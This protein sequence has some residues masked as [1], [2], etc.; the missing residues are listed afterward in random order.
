MTLVKGRLRRVGRSFAGYT[1][2]ALPADLVAGVTLAAIAIPE[3]MATARLAGFSPE[4]GFYAFI[5]GA[6]GFALFGGA[7]R[8][9]AGADSTIAPI[10]AGSLSLL[11]VAGSP[12]RA[13]LAAALA[14]MVGATLVIAGRLRMGYV[15]NLLSQPVTTGF[16]IGVALHIILSQAP[17]VL[18]LPSPN[19][20]LLHRARVLAGE[21]GAVN[22][23][24]AAIG[25]GVFGIVI[26]GER[27][28]ARV[29]SALIGLALA[30]GAVIAFDLERRGVAVLGS[31]SG[32]VPHFAWPDVA[33]HDVIR[34]V[35]LTLVVS[36]I[37]MVQT[38]AVS[39]GFAEADA[40]PDVDRDF[41]GLGAGSL[42]AG[43]FGAFPVNASPPRT[44]IAAET[45]A[46][47]QL[48]SLTAAA[49]LLAILLGGAALLTHVPQAAL[50]GVLF[51]VAQRIIRLEAVAR[52]WRWSRAEFLL[53]VATTAAIIVLPI[54][55]GVAFGIALSVLHGVWSTT[56][57]R[58]IRFER[59][60][61]T[62]IWWPPAPGRSGEMLPG[63]LV[64]AFQAPLSFLNAYD[65]RA[66][67]E[68]LIAAQPAP[69]RVLVIEASAIL[70]I[71]VTAGA[72]FTALIE[73]CRSEGIVVAL[74]RLE[75]LRAQEAAARLGIIDAL[76]PDR[77]FLSVDEATRALT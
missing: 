69:V 51:F 53:I 41:L 63:V 38:A 9:S 39:R 30:T 74:A 6:V 50:G 43:L 11:A 57:A 36:A 4:V 72:L 20:A 47:S 48:A 10:F 71:D 33:L 18:G 62:T 34:L 3:Q 15:A 37:V 5:A 31:V 14:L 26:L 32:G 35:P 25:F 1:A 61:G 28:S 76:G 68:A 44:A 77:V 23:Y 54:E 13:G 60:P 22:P 73:H 52:T 65:F 27:I 58:V 12:E 2:A 66:G 56:R 7:R 17:A 19:G 16:L 45:G 64:A 29:P 49:I 67:L 70:E 24:S 8:L 55:Q 21:L 59:R 40:P 42:L 75:S 46:R